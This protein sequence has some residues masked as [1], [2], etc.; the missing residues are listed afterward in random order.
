MS[1][2]ESTTIPTDHKQ[3]FTC[4]LVKPLTQFHK[5]KR[6]PDGYEHQCKDCASKRKGYTYRRQD[7]PKGQYRPDLDAFE[8]QLTK[9]YTALVDLAD[10]DL[11]AFDWQCFETPNSDLVYARN[12]KGRQ[13]TLLH[14]AVLER[15]L[16]RKLSRQE[17][18]D[19]IDRNG[20]NCRRSNLRLATRSENMQN[21]KLASNNKSGYRGVSYDK[22]KQKWIATIGYGGEHI[23]LGGYDT[24]EEANKVR[25]AAAKQLHG[26]FARF[27]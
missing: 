21:R 11:D 16:N 14:R 22:V 6:K 1:E 25:V 9:G 10:A 8:I 19:H 4:K 13:T 2:Q 3:C 23:Y 15:I 12:S 18:V 24:P 7:K 5:N 26:K 27:D 17:H 20:L